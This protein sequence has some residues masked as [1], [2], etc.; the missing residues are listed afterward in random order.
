MYKISE[1][2]KMIGFS[3]PTL[4]YYE[5]LG[6]STPAKNKN[7]YREYSEADIDWLRFIHRLKQTGM[8]LETIKKYSKLR[9]QGDQTIEKRMKLL[10]AQRNRLLAEKRK[11]DDHLFFLEN[12]QETYK[13]MLVNRRS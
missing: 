12:K 2:S 10:A 3:I 6:I 13:K 9:S 8:D 1:V 5:E 4:R 11:I 7:G